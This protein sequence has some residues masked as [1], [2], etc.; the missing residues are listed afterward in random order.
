M[1]KFDILDGGR[2]YQGHS[3]LERFFAQ[4][5]L[6]DRLDVAFFEGQLTGPDEPD[7]SMLVLVPPDQVC[8]RLE[9][10]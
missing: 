10:S 6:Q 8:R 3:V 5:A 7:T 4:E 2:I 9:L 1:L